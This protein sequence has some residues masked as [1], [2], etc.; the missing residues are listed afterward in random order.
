MVKTNPR[1]LREKKNLKQEVSRDFEIE[2]QKVTDDD[3][4]DMVE[5]SGLQ[6]TEI[7][8]CIQWMILRQNRAS[9]APSLESKSA[10]KDDKPLKTSI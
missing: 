10:E 3:I 1:N 9:P 8:F 5:Q 2:G 6:K 7:L 4:K